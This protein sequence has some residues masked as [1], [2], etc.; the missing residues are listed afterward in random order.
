MKDVAVDELI[1]L[2]KILL[3]LAHNLALVTFV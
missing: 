2:Q 3:A 1:D